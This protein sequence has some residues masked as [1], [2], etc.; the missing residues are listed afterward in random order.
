MKRTQTLSLLFGCSVNLCSMVTIIDAE[1]L[2][3]IPTG[4][5][6]SSVELKISDSNYNE[7]DEK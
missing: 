6:E 3:K 4:I 7:I 2:G 5:M 1:M